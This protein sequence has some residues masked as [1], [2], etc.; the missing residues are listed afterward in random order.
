MTQLAADSQNRFAALSALFTMRREE[1]VMN[2][3]LLLHT[4][5][6][7]RG[8]VPGTDA[9]WMRRW[10]HCLGVGVNGC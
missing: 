8:E 1:S 3:F 7:I 2:A 10:V 4:L 5:C 9:R 6:E